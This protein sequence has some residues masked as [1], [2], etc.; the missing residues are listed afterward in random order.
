MTSLKRTSIKLI[1]I[2]SLLG[3]LF[4]T[5]PDSAM[6]LSV[7]V[8]PG[9][10]EI[11]LSEENASSSLNI[12][13]SDSKTSHYK[14][15]IADAAYEQYFNIEPSEFDLPGNSTK[16]ININVQDNC[17]LQ[18]NFTAR[19]SIVSVSPDSGLRCGA[20]IRVP[21]IVRNYINN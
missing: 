9:K 3:I 15:Y 5:F 19:I 14:I 7:G 12:I 10:L 13:N 20:G 4:F 17:N 8:T 6:A 11:N 1:M 2:L 18:Y 16:I 21:V